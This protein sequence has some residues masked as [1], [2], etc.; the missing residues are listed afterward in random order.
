VKVIK[1]FDRK[2]FRGWKS[3][4]TI[5]GFDGI[6]IGHAAILEYLCEMARAKEGKG[7][8]VTFDPLPRAFFQKELFKVITT[9]EE[10]LE[11]L[12]NIGV[13]GVFI[14]S[15]TDTLSRLSAGDFLEKVWDSFHPLGI[16]VGHN[17][18]FGRDGRGGIPLLKS[19]SREKGIDLKVVKEV[20]FDGEIV[21]STRIRREIAHGNVKVAGEM[22]DRAFSF[23]AVVTKGNGIGRA[24][25]YP[26]ANLSPTSEKKVLPLHGV[27]AAKVLIDGIEYGAML[28]LGKRPTFFEKGRSSIEVYVMGYEGNLYDKEI[29]VRVIERIREE[30]KFSSAE[31]LKDQIMNDEENAR[32][33]I[34]RLAIQQGG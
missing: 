30:K 7:I 13:D 9:T 21:S 12:E 24:L 19:Y 33:I 3:V 25:T 22:L 17:H 31:N 6:H 5:G 34:E 14:I 27:Y 20:L 4:I 15:F 18:H 1:G 32:K 10:K 11:I 29:L 2:D 28:Y 8:V 26:T 23:S 16:I